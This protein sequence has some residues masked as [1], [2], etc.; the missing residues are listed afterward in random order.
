MGH[1]GIYFAETTTEATADRANVIHSSYWEFLEVVRNFASVWWIMERFLVAL[2]LRRTMKCLE[3]LITLRAN[4][5]LINCC[6]DSIP[7]CIRLKVLATRPLIINLHNFPKI[8]IR[9][10]DTLLKIFRHLFILITQIQSHMPACYRWQIDLFT[11]L[12]F[13]DSSWRGYLVPNLVPPC[14]HLLL[15]TNLAIHEGLIE[16]LQELFHI[17][18]WV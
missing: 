3:A 17:G 8:W 2:H 9:F 4:L 10:S 5:C 7:N 1:Q 13:L 12:L 6:H 18:N 14:I 11:W 15:L 16:L